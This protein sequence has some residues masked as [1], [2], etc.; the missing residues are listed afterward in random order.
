MADTAAAGGGEHWDARVQETRQYEEVVEPGTETGTVVYAET[1]PMGESEQM[2][3]NSELMETQNGFE[4]IDNTGAVVTVL[5]QNNN[6]GMASPPTELTG[7]D[8]SWF[9]VILFLANRL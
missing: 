5:Q 8:W 7:S 6:P 1:V 9:M 4:I 2:Y 3:H